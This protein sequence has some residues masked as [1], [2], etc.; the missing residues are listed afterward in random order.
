[1]VGILSEIIQN[2]TLGDGAPAS[3]AELLVDISACPF[4]FSVCTQRS[5]MCVSDSVP[6]L[7][8]QVVRGL[9]NNDNKN[10]LHLKSLIQHVLR[11]D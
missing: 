5:Y 9:G 7:L 3:T 4:T 1:M 6:D 2:I 11:R 10:G 8:E